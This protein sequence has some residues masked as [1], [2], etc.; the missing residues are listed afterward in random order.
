M[1]WQLVSSDGH[2][3]SGEINFDWQP[4][5]SQTISEGLNAPPACGGGTLDETAPTDESAPSEDG[6]TDESPAFDASTVVFVASAIVLV[7]VAG[8]AIF[9]ISVKRKKSDD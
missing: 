9:L 5:T 4:D 8:V 3:I 6:N 2:T 1:R 7:I